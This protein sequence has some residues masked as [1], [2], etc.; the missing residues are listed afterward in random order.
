MALYLKNWNDI[1]CTVLKDYARSANGWAFETELLGSVG[2]PSRQY[3]RIEVW[4][5]CHEMK[6]AGK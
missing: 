4:K 5:F 3:K 1:F 6:G 2:D